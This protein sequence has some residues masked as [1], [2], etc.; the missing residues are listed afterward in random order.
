M[1][2]EICLFDFVGTSRI[3]IRERRDINQPV[4]SLE[5]FRK[6]GAWIGVRCVDS[7]VQPINPL[8]SYE[9]W[10]S[11]HDEKLNEDWWFLAR[12]VDRKFVSELYRSIGEYSVEWSNGERFLLKLE[13]SD[14]EEG[15]TEKILQ[16]F[17]GTFLELIRSYNN[18]VQIKHLDC[19][20]NEDSLFERLLLDYTQSLQKIVD[21]P[22]S[23]IDLDASFV[24][25]RKVKGNASD[26]L[27]LSR[28]RHGNVIVSRRIKENIK[29]SENCFVLFCANKVLMLLEALRFY[30]ESHLLEMKNMRRCEILIRKYALA[31]EMAGVRPSSHS[32]NKIVFQ[33]N[34]WYAKNFNCYKQLIATKKRALEG[35]YFK[36]E[37]ANVRIE[38]LS[39]IYEKWCLLRII[40]TLFLNYRF[41][42]DEYWIKKLI[43]SVKKSV[44][45]ISITFQHQ[46]SLQ[47]IRLTYQCEFE[48]QDGST[49]RPDYVLESINDD[50]TISSPC[51]LV[52]DA[53]LRTFIGKNGSRRLMINLRDDKDY[54]DEGRNMVFILH[55]CKSLKNDYGLADQSYSGWISA[56]PG[57][58]G[59]KL[60]VLEWLQ[61]LELQESNTKM[62]VCYQCG[63]AGSF[64]KETYQGDSGSFVCV[65]GAER[66]VS[67]CFGCCYKPLIKNGKVNYFDYVPNNPKNVICPSCGGR[68]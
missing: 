50:G 9:K 68:F 52:L 18:P 34:R 48:I 22:K 26:I 21:K 32:F 31:L 56:F 65:C 17:K 10:Y 55:P 61:F 54:G 35:Y 7:F 8:G 11:A 14:L 2:F 46:D 15:I 49:V 4:I 57:S 59:I 53:K 16:D 12:R 1:K 29:T 42:P 23:K 39:A 58:S 25:A 38:H 13:C 63:H 24:L 47:K 67:H 64:L 30:K 19:H 3:E 40:H 33:S 60:V 28:K 27:Q 41:V 66:I 45:N 62:R 36:S 6:V 44:N 51:K 43:A 5:I 20:F 37:V